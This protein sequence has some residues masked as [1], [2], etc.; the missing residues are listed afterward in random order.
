MK[1]NGIKQT[2]FDR[3]EINP[4]EWF[5]GFDQIEDSIKSSVDL[6]SNHPLL[7]TRVPVHGLVIDPET[8]QLDL[9]INGY[10]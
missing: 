9:V 1:Q 2:D 10:K 4:H 8:G 5:R 7:P 3:L 6:I